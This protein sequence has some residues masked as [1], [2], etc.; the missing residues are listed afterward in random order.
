[1]KRK[2]IKEVL[3]DQLIEHNER[4]SRYSTFDGFKK[5]N[6]KRSTKLQPRMTSL[7]SYYIYDHPA[8]K[9]VKKVEEKLIRHK[10]EAITKKASQVLDEEEMPQKVPSSRDGAVEMTTLEV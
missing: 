7:C 4:L 9:D 1:M 3:Q 2:D 6:E 10:G 5:L 8:F